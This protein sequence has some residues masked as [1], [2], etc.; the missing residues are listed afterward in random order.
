MKIPAAQ[1][2]VQNTFYSG[3]TPTEF[4]HVVADGEGLVK[5]AETGYLQRR[6]VKCLAD[7]EVQYDGTVRNAIDE[8]VEF[9]FQIRNCS[10]S[11]QD[12]DSRNPRFLFSPSLT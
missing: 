7:L 8:V 10:G 12:I 11:W 2:F 9:T 3:L 1:G 6:F 4:F 5:T